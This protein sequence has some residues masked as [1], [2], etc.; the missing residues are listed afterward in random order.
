MFGPK[1]TTVLIFYKIK[2]WWENL[3]KIHLP[4]ER[5][6]LGREELINLVKANQLLEIEI[7][8]IQ[9]LKNFPPEKMVN[10]GKL[11]K[12]FFKENPYYYGVP[13]KKTKKNKT[14]SRS[15]I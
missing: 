4:E 3:K 1:S 2:M 13:I 15:F 11:K 6:H 9:L 10:F 14:K 7:R 5:R 12:A 8:K